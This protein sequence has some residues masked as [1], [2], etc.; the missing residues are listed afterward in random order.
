MMVPLAENGENWPLP[1]AKPWVQAPNAKCNRL[2]QSW[3][4]TY[5]DQT[6]GTYMDNNYPDGTTIP[7]FPGQGERLT[8]TKFLSTDM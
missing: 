1:I 5:G 6:A 3:Q 2:A 4:L 8:P 7:A